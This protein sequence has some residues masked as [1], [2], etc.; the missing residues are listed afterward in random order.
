MT[1]IFCSARNGARFLLRL[2]HSRDSLLS[3]FGLATLKDR[4]LLDGETPQIMFARVASWFADDNDHAQRLY[5]YMSRL[6]FMPSTPVLSNGGTSRGNPISCFLNYV[7]DSLEGIADVY[8]ENLWLAS[9]GGGIGTYWGD[10]RGSQERVGA[11]GHSSGVIPFLKVMDSNTLAISQGSLRRG[12]AAVYLDIDHPDIEEFLEMR[13]PSG[14]MNRKSL[15]LHHGVNLSDAFMRAVK[16]GVEWDLIGRKDGA[17]VKTVSA[18]GLWQ[19]ILT[20]RMQTGEPYILWTDTV[21]RAQ[22]FHHQLLGM[23][24]RQSNLCSEITLPTGTDYMGNQRTAVC[25]LSSLNLDTYLDWHDNDAF[26]PDV[27]NFLDNVLQDF[28]DRTKGVRGFERARYAAEMERSIG[29]GTMGL[30]SFLQS[31]GVPMD[32]LMGKVWNEKIF[33][34]IRKR[35]DAANLEAAALKGPCPDSAAAHEIKPSIPLIRWSYA[36]ATAPT[37]SISIICGGVSP[38][39]EPFNANA[40]TQ[41]TLSGSF[42][43]RNRYLQQ[44]ILDHARVKFEPFPHDHLEREIDDWVRDQWSSINEHEG[45]VQHLDWLDDYQKEVF[46]TAFEINQYA[47]VVMMGDRAGYV[48][49]AVSNNL[50]L[51]PDIDVQDLS[52]LHMMAWER[53]VKSLYYCRSKSIARAQK[54]TTSHVAGEMPLPEQATMYEEC[55]FCS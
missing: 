49:Q 9:K 33:R 54:I 23:K 25:C 51:P 27:L 47:L 11:V 15:N 13:K 44:I 17:V 42:P 53:N 31:Q 40:F 5:D 29:L 45:S 39:V 35:V 26:Y 28:I 55:T 14:D 38:G 6:W 2:D 21:N 22:P 4:Y 3:D 34:N 18:R 46:K 16:A 37:A 10:V 41:K 50:F 43:V 48:H 1:D 36:L 24:V 12:S 30:Q 7:P 52:R 19:K 8:E 20:L 32:G